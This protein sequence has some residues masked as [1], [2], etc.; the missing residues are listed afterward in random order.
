MRLYK[1]LAPMLFAATAACGQLPTAIADEACPVNQQMATLAQTLADNPKYKTHDFRGDE[2]DKLS[3]AIGEPP[4]GTD[5]V[6]EV[7]I[8]ADGGELAALIAFKDNC[9]LAKGMMPKAAL[10]QA[11]GRASADDAAPVR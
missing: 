7:D 1:F 2:L 6:V 4:E 8:P 10:D 5:E 9:A 11:L 3:D